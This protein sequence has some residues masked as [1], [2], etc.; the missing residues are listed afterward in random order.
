MSHNTW[1]HRAVRS[2]VRPLVDTPVTPNHLTTLR[3]VSG[4]GAAVCLSSPATAWLW[5]GCGLFLLSMLL[6]RAD[7]ELAR[8]SGKTSDWGHLYDIATDAVCNSAVLIGVGVGL[9]T[10]PLGDYA[11]AMGIISGAA[12]CLY[13]LD[14][15]RG[16]NTAWPG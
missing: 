14:G 6:D 13:L 4:I 9:R 2:A 8:L 7:G 16:R 12:V 11:I 15:A 10:G 3:L 1:I 5:T